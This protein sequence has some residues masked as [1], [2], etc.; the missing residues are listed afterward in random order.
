VKKKTLAGLLVA[1]LAVALAVAAATT[2]AGARSTGDLRGAGSSFVSPLVSLW[3][4]NYK[5][6]QIS[7][8]AVGSGAG[9]AAISNRSVDFGASDAPMTPDQRAGCHGCVEIPWALSATSIP[10][11][12][13]G[14]PYGLKITGP[15]LADIYLGKITHWNDKRIQKFNPKAKLPSTKIVPIYRSDAS[16]TTYNFTEYLS[17]VSS[18]FRNKVGNSTTVNFPVG[19]GASKSA[20][21]SA[22][23]NRTEGGI[24]YVD[25]AFSLKN[26]FKFFKV[27]NSAKK[28][29]LPGLTGIGAAAATVKKVPSNNIIHIVDPPKSQKL[30]YPICTFTYVILPLKS[31]SANE[32]KP[33]VKWA[34]TSGQKVPGAQ[35][36]VF[37]P[38]PKAVAKATQKTLKKVHA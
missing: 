18:A 32:L 8:N 15:V 28:F 13:S 33:F 34:V 24:A 9:I 36:L 2:P 31:S 6:S 27:Q 37:Y 20:G 17:K 25:V 11:H 21:V 30:A 1:V 26:H 22:A 4:A 14:A 29:T 23:L 35:K 10:Y 12:L 3:I 19:I 16:G 5:K 38:L 7:Y